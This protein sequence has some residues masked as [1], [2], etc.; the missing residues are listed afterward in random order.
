MKS[1]TSS[2]ECDESPVPAFMLDVPSCR[3]LA[4]FR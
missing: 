4:L 2:S 3:H 1:A